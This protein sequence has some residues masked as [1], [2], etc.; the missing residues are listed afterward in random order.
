MCN[1]ILPYIDNADWIS[2]ETDKLI[3]ICCAYRP[4]IYRS[5]QSCSFVEGTGYMEQVFQEI[6]FVLSSNRGNCFIENLDEFIRV[7]ELEYYEGHKI[8]ELSGGWKKFLGLALFT[9][10]NCPG[11]IYFDA[12][13]QLSDHL[14]A[15]LLKNL[16]QT[17]TNH[18]WFFEYDV[19]LFPNDVPCGKVAI[20]QL[21]NGVVP[22]S[23]EKQT[24]LS[25]TNY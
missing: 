24:L 1:I 10:I 20:T 4:D 12:F 5:Y 11:K 22:L 23:S 9:N 13:R 18:A 17:A 14:I 8:S 15:L 19:T 2:E 6:D 21:E 3:S 16:G 25:E 7:W